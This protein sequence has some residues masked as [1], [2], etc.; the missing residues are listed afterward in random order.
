M[1]CFFFSF[2][3]AFYASP[4]VSQAGRVLVVTWMLLCLVLASV[5]SS[6]LTSSLT[7]SEQALPFNSLAQLISQNTY[8]WGLAAGT[9]QEAIL[10]VS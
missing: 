1:P 7:V 4:V 3:L 2:I 5:Y 10:R 8:T 9:A 6:K